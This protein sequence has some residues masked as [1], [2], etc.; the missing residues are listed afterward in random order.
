MPGS[1]PWMIYVV[2]LPLHT[3]RGTRFIP[4]NPMS[5]IISSRQEP[6][7]IIMKFLQAIP[8]KQSKWLDSTSCSVVCGGSGTKKQERATITPAR[9][10][11]TCGP[12]EQTVSCNQGSCP[13]SASSDNP[14]TTTTSHIE[15]RNRRDMTIKVEVAPGMII[16]TKSRPQANVEVPADKSSDS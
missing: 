2:E 9:G 16:T 3:R 8:C 5:W 12:T 13:T 15:N 11:G 4:L 14:G 6:A 10:K 1:F 7:L